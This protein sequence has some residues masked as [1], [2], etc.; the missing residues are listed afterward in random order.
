MPAV[1]AVH[2]RKILDKFVGLQPEDTVAEF[3]DRFLKNATGGEG[4]GGG[5]AGS[6]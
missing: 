1:F 4:S 6:E 2:K 3:V 5:G